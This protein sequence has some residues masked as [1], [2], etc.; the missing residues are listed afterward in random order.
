MASSTS[1]ATQMS[2]INLAGWSANFQDTTSDNFPKSTQSLSSILSQSA[3]ASGS[4]QHVSNHLFR[5]LLSGAGW[6]EK[7][8]SLQV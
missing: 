6:K 4:A 8:R 1:S 2:A 5:S 7:H 3:V